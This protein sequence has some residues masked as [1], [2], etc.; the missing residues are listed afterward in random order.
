MN[1]GLQALVIPLLPWT[2]HPQDAAPREQFPQQSP[3]IHIAVDVDLPGMQGGMPGIHVWRSAD[4]PLQSMFNLFWANCVTALNSPV[5]S[6]IEAIRPGSTQTSQLVS[7]VELTVQIDILAAWLWSLAK[8][9]WQ[10][11]MPWR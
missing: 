3:G 5:D 1:P 9:P 7:T 10:A 2:L 4:L 8:L 6:G 11:F